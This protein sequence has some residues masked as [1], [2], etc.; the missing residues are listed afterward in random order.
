MKKD[1]LYSELNGEYQRLKNIFDEAIGKP[2]N[3]NPKAMTL[4][5]INSIVKVS[6]VMIECMDTIQKIASTEDVYLDFIG[7]CVLS[8]YL[9]S[10]V[11]GF[12]T[13]SLPCKC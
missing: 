7:K 9:E 12:N 4:S 11:K 2:G 13:R 3:I 8:Y 1:E 5:G 10:L 6:T